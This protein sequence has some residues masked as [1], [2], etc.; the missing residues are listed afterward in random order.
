MEMLVRTHCTLISTGTEL[1]ILTAEY[2]PGSAWARYGKY[3]FVPGYNSVGEVIEVGPGVENQWLGK[4]VASYAPH[5]AFVITTPQDVRVV[6]DGLASDEAAFF[7]IAEIVMN[8]VRRGGV[9]WGEAVGVF[10]LGLLG[11]FTAR[12]CHFAGARPVIGIDLAPTRI[13]LLPTVRGIVGVNPEAEDLGARVKDLTRNRF[14]DVVFEVTGRSD[15]IPGQFA[16]LRKLGR[17]VVLSSPRGNASFSFHDL[18]NS[19]SY[20]IIGAHNASHP[21][22]AT[23]LTPWSRPRHAELFFDLV[24][25]GELDVRHLISHRIPHTEAPEVYRMLLEDRSQAM[26]VVIHWPQA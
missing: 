12:F 26:G 21:P 24:L 22:A 19:P 8:G 17:L 2:E 25:A 11:Q 20:T 3:P 4:R 6:P 7:T 16:Y 10:G 18:C 5:A 15:A 23:L 1:T 14:L 9:T 13:A